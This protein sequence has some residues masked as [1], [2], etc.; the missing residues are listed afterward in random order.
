MS[1]DKILVIKSFVSKQRESICDTVKSQG[2]IKN[3][4]QIQNL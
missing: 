3:C 1:C 4:T 2:D